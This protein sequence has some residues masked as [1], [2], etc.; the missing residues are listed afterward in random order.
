MR[1]NA[2]CVP[3]L[4]HPCCLLSHTIGR[5]PLVGGARG[6]DLL[7][8]DTCNQPAGTDP[9]VVYP[10][11]GRALNATGRDIW[12][13]CCAVV[14]PLLQLQ[15]LLLALLLVVLVLVVV[16]VVVVVL[17][18]CWQWWWCW[19]C[20]CCVLAGGAAGGAAAACWR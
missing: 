12:W 8:Y 17:R 18:A 9:K 6:V 15:L 2:R 4:P 10:K 3:S 20:C 1:G 11:M 14:L 16:V 13:A 5:G 19:R 7:K